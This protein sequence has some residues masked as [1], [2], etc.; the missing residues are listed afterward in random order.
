[1]IPVVN[2][3]YLLIDDGGYVITKCT[4]YESDVWYFTDYMSYSDP[5]QEWTMIDPDNAY[6][7]RVNLGSTAPC[8]G[9]CLLT[10]LQTNYPELLI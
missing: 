2:N 9:V 8:I 10:F 1:M 3:Y 6:V 7:L 4:L 5:L